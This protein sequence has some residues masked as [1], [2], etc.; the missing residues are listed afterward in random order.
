MK[1]ENLRRVIYNLKNED[2]VEPGAFDVSEEE[3]NLYHEE[4]DGYFHRWADEIVFEDE[5][6]FQRTYGIVE[7]AET[8]QVK[9]I[10]P[11]QIKFY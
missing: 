10:V 9:H 11:K 5:E 7:D 6:P 2:Y 3:Y 1:R 4:K 8:G